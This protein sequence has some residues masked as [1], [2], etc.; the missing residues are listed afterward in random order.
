MQM[1]RERRAM[2][3]LPRP[4]ST[5]RK[6]RDRHDVSRAVLLP[7]ADPMVPELEVIDAATAL[8]DF[9]AL[10]PAARRDL[11]TA[12]WEAGL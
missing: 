11:L 10:P 1:E 6:R 8:D 5:G 2:P 3:V 12:S 7:S 9:L 4:E